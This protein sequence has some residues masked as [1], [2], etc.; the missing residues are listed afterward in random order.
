MN[1]VG[2]VVAQLGSL[3]ATELGLVR[4]PQ[5]LHHRA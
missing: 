4:G 3:R 2:E 5:S 1:V